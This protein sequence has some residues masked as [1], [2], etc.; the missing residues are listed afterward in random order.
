MDSC[1]IK[2]RDSEKSGHWEVSYRQQL[3]H[4]VKE[5]VDVLT[6]DCYYPD[7]GNPLIVEVDLVHARATDPIRIQFDFGRNGWRVLQA[8]IFEYEVHDDDEPLYDLP[9]EWQE[10][11]F[12]PAWNRRQHEDGNS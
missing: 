11:A 5:P 6:V 4:W 7:A 1:T 2:P 3:P 10:V 9:G 8:S 12:I